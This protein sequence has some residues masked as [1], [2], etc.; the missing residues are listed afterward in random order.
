M[1][2]VG[3]LLLALM[4][5][6]T[7]IVGCGS[8]GDS[9]NSGDT[10]NTGESGNTGD[11]GDAADAGNTGESEVYRV[12]YIARAQADSFAAMLAN[13]IVA[14]AEKY[15][16]IRV[17]VMDGEASDEKVNSLIENS[18]TEG[19]DLIIVQPNNG[20]S[21]RPFVEQ[22]VDA[23]IFA[24]TTNARI[25]GIEG[26]SSVD[27]DPYSQAK[28]NAD[29]AV[30]QVP[31]NASVVVLNGP[32]GN[33]HADERRLSW[34]VEFFDKR[35]DVTIVGE[36]IANWN[37][38]EGMLY[39]EDWIQSN[40]NIDAV[41]SMNDTMAAG[42]LEAVKDNPQFEDMLVYGVDGQPEAMLLIKEGKLTATSMQSYL[43]LSE[44]LLDTADK[45]LTGKE[46]V[47]DVDIPNPLITID[48][49]DEYIEMY[50]NA[51]AYN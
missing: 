51:N 39:M 26:A 12:A 22:I 2:K 31:E 11:T 14:E 45:L 1:K 9:G 43:D 40:S 13:A 7:M 49:V 46:T 15:P 48:N 10:G 20:E 28:V 47:I 41:I 16:H 30:T 23:G 36:Q 38:D 33:F 37:K 35:P 50:E 27:A 42:A 21:Q 17:F 5:S 4:L 25:A 3:V 34:Q 18:I 19:Y 24:I 29:A 8:S 6:M 32:P 44:L